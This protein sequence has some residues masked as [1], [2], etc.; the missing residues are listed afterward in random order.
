[1]T[2]YETARRLLIEHIQRLRSAFREFKQ[3][4]VLLGLGYFMQAIG[5]MN[6]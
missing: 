6:A 3:E 1:M 2:N 5:Q 4:L